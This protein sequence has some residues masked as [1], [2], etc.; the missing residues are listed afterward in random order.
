MS[1]R[2]S[3][4]RV[5]SPNEPD[6]GWTKKRKV[7]PEETVEITKSE[8]DIAEEAIAYVRREKTRLMVISA[9]DFSK[10]IQEDFLVENIMLGITKRGLTNTVRRTLRDVK[11]ALDTAS[12]YDAIYEIS[13]VPEGALDATIL[14][15]KRLLEFRNKIEDYLKITRATIYNQEI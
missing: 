5:S 11:N 3:L 9:L 12:L 13:Q 15:E 7:K 4:N 14:T 1:N 2:K 8:K 10:Q 6:Y